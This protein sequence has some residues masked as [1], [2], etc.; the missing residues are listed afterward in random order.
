MRRRTPVPFSRRR[1]TRSD[2]TMAATTRPRPAASTNAA[3]RT[4]GNPTRS[5]SPRARASA[6]PQA[7]FALSSTSGRRPRKGCRGNGSVAAP[8]QD[9]KTFP[10]RPWTRAPAG[11]IAIESGNDIALMES[12]G[13]VVQKLTNQT[14]TNPNVW[15]DWSPDGSMIV[16]AGA[17]EDFDLY[18]MNSDGGEVVQITRGRGGRDHPGLVS[19]R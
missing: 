12:G 16:F 1:R 2:S 18:V 17:S 13:Y 5:C 9:R 10:D 3:E 8:A 11:M 15:A 14:Q 6:R 19:G 7:S 4:C